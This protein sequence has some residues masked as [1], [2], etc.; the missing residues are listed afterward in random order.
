MRASRSAC[1]T[2]GSSRTRLP[3]SGRT[4]SA[5]GERQRP[6]SFITREPSAAYGAGGKTKSQV[7][8]DAMLRRIAVTFP[9]MKA[10][11]SSAFASVDSSLR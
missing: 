2:P 10:V 6:S 9:S 4:S 11:S 1:D 8:P 7:S 5:S 3:S